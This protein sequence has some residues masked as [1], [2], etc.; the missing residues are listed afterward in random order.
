MRRPL[1]GILI[2]GFAFAA[3]V[4]SGG[5]IKAKSTPDAARARF[6]YRDVERFI[7]VLRQL[8]GASDRAQVLR[9]KY[10][11]RGT[12]GL[13]MFVEKYGLTPQGLQEAIH[14]HQ[15]AYRTLGDKLAALRAREAFFRAS[16]ARLVAL[17]PH[18]EFPPTYF[19]VGAHNNIASGSIRG[20][21]VS[22]ERRTA[23]SI[24]AGLEATLVHEMVHMQQLRALGE[25]YFAV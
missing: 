23:K 19:L 20:T 17:I 24:A 25:R 21:L 7:A 16:Y 4:P 12:P 15:E 3:P 9:S 14:S 1:A 22:V 2:F 5:P 6:V 10:I 8:E 13:K 18:A 11:E